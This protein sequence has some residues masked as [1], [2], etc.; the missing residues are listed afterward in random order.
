MGIL[1]SIFG[2]GKK[3]D[4][5]GFVDRHSHI[6]PGVDD[7]FQNIEDSLECLDAYEK[8]GFSKLWLTPHIMED[9]PNRTE[10]LKNRF[11]QL[12]QAYKGPMEL[13]LASENMID[14]LFADRLDKDDLLPMDDMLLVETSYYNPPRNFDEILSKI[15][16]KGYFPLLAHPERYI[17]MTSS[18]YERLLGEGIKF[19]LNIFSLT[20]MYGIPARDKALKLL[21]QGAYSFA[22]SDIHNLRQLDM[23]EKL[24]SNKSLS[25][26]VLAI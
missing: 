1:S 4:F 23:L 9:F 11:E 15:K 25:D 3:G 10:D 22:G 5:N 7:G 13:H 12:R 21:K 14:T 2:T 16:N 8:Q 26:K 17:Y 20:G 24:K 18:D 6:L 19:Q